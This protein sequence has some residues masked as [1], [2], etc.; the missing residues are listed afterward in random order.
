[1]VLWRFT[2]DSNAA[3]VGISADD[4]A[5]YTGQRGIPVV[6]AL[7]VTDGQP[8][9]RV[10]VGLSQG[11]QSPAFI[12]GVAVSGD[13][14]YAGVT[15]FKNLNGGM[16]TGVVVAL[17]RTTGA[18]LWRYETPTESDDMQGR[19]VVTADALIVNDFYGGATIALNRAT[20]A[21]R[22]RVKST[23]AGFGPLAPAVVNGDHVYIGSEDTYI[24]DVSLASGQVLWK[25][26]TGTSLDGVTACGSSVWG[27]NGGLERHSAADGHQTGRYADTGARFTSN[28]ATDGSHLYL[29][30]YGGVYAIQC[31]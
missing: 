10:N 17:D 23:G 2:P 5:V 18:E 31:D 11:W 3:Q 27:M 24:Y 9:W 30:G 15:R 16:S 29:T 1:G 4:H 12:T 20:G 22:W 28:L 19:P 8:L 26:N 14:V 25:S 21:E 13:T 6:Y 7:A